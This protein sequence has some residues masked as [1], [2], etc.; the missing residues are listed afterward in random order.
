MADGQKPPQMYKIYINETPLFLQR[1][2]PEGAFGMS[3][4]EVL[5]ARYT[6]KVKSLFNYADMLE[7]S[8]RYRS[9]TL[10][11]EDYEQLV[12]DFESHYQIIEA[13]GGVVYNTAGEVLFIFRLDSWDLPKGKIDEGEDPPT[14]A[15]REVQ[16]ETGLVQVDLGDFLCHSWHT[17]RTGKGKRILKKTHWYKMYTQEQALTPQAEENIA[18]AVWRAP[19]AVLSSGEPLYGSIR[20]VLLLL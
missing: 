13:A 19:A 10:Y 9:V 6:G 15:V 18:E 16:E 2:S 11:S 7:K 14:A 8:R 5:V 3:S 20:D 12:A 4:D 1:S 17:Y